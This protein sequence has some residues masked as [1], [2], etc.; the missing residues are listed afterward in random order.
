IPG[1]DGKDIKLPVKADASSGGL[2]VDT[3]STESMTLDPQLT[4]TLRGFWGF[5]PYEGPKF[6]LRTSRPGQWTIPASDQSALIVGRED[7][8]RI[9]SDAAVCVDDVKIRDAQGNEIK[10]TWKA[11]KPDEVELKVAM[12]DRAAGPLTAQVRQYGLKKA[13]EVKLQ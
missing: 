4:G 13:D 8:L 9:Q 1:K 5:E 2:L 11:T 10:T 12:K 3:H 6:H 7:T